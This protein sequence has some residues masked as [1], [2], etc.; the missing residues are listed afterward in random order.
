MSI[1]PIDL[2]GEWRNATMTAAALELITNLLGLRPPAP[3][4][5]YGAAWRAKCA[6]V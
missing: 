2:C 3:N 1:P 5:V 6:K 4:V